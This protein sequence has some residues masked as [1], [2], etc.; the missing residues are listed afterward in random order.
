MTD[1]SF[2]VVA[3][4]VLGD[5]QAGPAIRTI[6]LANELA[7]IGHVTVLYNGEIPDNACKEITFTP[8]DDLERSSDFFTKFTA[9]LAPPLVAMNLPELLDSDIPICIDLFD[10]VVWENLD[11]YS[12]EPV[13][14]Q[15]FQHERH[16]AALIAALLRGDYFLVAGKRQQ[17][18]FLGALMSLNRI[19]PAIFKPGNVIEDII[20]YV[21]FGI[22][23]KTI[24]PDINL[25]PEEFRGDSPMIVWG[26]GLWDWLCPEIIVNA[27]PSVLKKFPDARLIFPG[28][29]HPNPHLPVPEKLHVV[30]K[31]AA[32]LNIEKSM[33][34]GKWLPENEYYNL[35]AVASC[36]VSAHKPGLESRYAVRTRFMGF[37]QMGLPMVVS[38]GDEYS[39]IVSLGGLGNVV[40]TP[41]PSD[42]ASAI[43]DVLE[44]G[45][46]TYTSS[47]GAVRNSLT[48]AKTSEPLI[49]WM[50][51]P[52][53]THGKG[54]SF[55]SETLGGT[56]PRN[57]PTD[58]GS[59]MGRVMKK[60]K[61][62]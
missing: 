32:E 23:E 6:A 54:A 13:P 14:E 56:S 44:K 28:T 42:F 10:P 45:R 27:M 55:F 35:L 43:I 53:L 22:P 3:Y 36:G 21:P 26:G 38:G 62:K 31:L 46:E 7:K 37:I 25:V 52:T 24:E 18:L 1:N 8:L 15:E 34:Y 41:A 20:G 57:R 60:L 50:H 19:N 16:L 48:W 30:S 11:L 12:L 39:S 49:K 47:F 17:D 29:I 40:A 58:L 9:A 61:K 51:S 59:L 5:V 4:D 33:F 2:L